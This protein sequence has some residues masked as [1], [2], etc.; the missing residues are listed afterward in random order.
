[1]E[2]KSD[3]GI[4]K[5]IELIGRYKEKLKVAKYNVIKIILNYNYLMWYLKSLSFFS[6]VLEP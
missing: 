6:H 4:K 2:V 5:K 3:V 1:M